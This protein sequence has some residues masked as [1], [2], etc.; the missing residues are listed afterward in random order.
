[1]GDQDLKGYTTY[2]YSR[3]DCSGQ[4]A[5]VTH[6]GT[7]ATCEKISDSSSLV[8]WVSAADCTDV[9]AEWCCPVH[10]DD[11]NTCYASSTC[12]NK[13]YWFP[14]SGTR[15]QADESGT[16]CSNDNDNSTSVKQA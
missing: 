1:M 8:R 15:C 13:C 3:S 12:G 2:H 5:S 7:D 10:S 11:C 16:G 6:Y 4:A 14:N 9:P